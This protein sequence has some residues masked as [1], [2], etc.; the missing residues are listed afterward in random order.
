MLDSNVI[1]YV[2]AGD[3]ARGRCTFD[4]LTGHGLCTLSNGMGK[5]AGVSADL[6]VSFIAGFS[7]AVDGNLS[8]PDNQQ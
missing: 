6:A 5:L 7:F 8:F 1:L 3:W 2:V 4:D